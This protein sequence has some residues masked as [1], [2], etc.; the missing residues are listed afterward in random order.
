M[1]E[2]KILIPSFEVERHT[3]SLNRSL[4]GFVAVISMFTVGVI[5]FISHLMFVSVLGLTETFLSEHTILGEMIPMVVFAIIFGIGVYDFLNHFLHS[6]II[7]DDRIVKGRIIDAGRVKGSDVA[8]KAAI[9]TYML[10]NIDDGAKVNGANGIG[11]L[12]AVLGLARRN[13][14]QTF[15]DNFFHT[16]LYKKKEY[17]HPHLIKETK[18]Y[19]LFSCDKNKKIRI[20]KMYTG[21][22]A[23]EKNHGRSSIVKRVIIRSLLVFLVF[24]MLSGIDLAVGASRNKENKDNIQSTV[25]ELEENLNVFGY[26]K[27]KV[28]EKFFRFEKVVSSEH[29]S[30]INCSID[31]DGSIDEVKF[32][33]YYNVD[34]GDIGPELSYIIKSSTDDFSEEQIGPFLENVQKIIHGEHTYD[35]LESKSSKIVLGTSIGYAHIHN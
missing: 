24:G 19:Y 2:D 27:N 13:M 12:V 6:Y 5:V 4:W 31:S 26:T 30:Y 18:H 16:D 20:D 11:N 8:L 32:E 7:N 14:D 10:A 15:V 3:Q 1:K 33:V 23:S 9:S 35:K 29:T 28:G 25:T 34:S 21:M 17:L 22:D